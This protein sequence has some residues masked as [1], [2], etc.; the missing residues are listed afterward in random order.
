MAVHRY[1][2]QCSAKA[3]NSSFALLAGPS[4]V[5]GDARAEEREK[6]KEEEKGSTARRIQHPAF[7]A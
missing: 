6:K 3:S 1:A 4:P 2:R 5:C 7:T